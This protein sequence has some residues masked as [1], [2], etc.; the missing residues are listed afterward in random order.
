MLVMRKYII[1]AMQQKMF[2]IVFDLCVLVNIVILALEGVISSSIVVSF[3][4]FL[5]LILLGELVL[6]LISQS[7]SKIIIFIISLEKY[8]EKGINIF[9]SLIVLLCLGEI[10]LV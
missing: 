3:N 4:N 7:I 8:F 5:T 10:L 6:K 2:E 9:E 1:R